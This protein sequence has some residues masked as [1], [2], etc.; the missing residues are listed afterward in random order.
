MADLDKELRKQLLALLKGG[1]A[2][3]TY[4]DAV[5]DLPAKLRGEVPAGLPYSA[6]QLVEHIRITLKDILE[7]SD[8]ADGKYKELKWPDEYWPKE[9][10]PP[11]EKAWTHSIA[12]YEKDLAAFEALV[13]KGD[14]TTP[15]AWGDGQNLLREAM[16]VA[17]H[18]A[19]HVGELI[20]LR[21]LLGAWK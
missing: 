21:R 1:Q 2:H 13:K 4:D 19:Y 5:K 18:T 14:L 15:F 12:E 17:D 10:E 16:L 3:A 11:T 9:K 8:N 20:V 6:W 7:F